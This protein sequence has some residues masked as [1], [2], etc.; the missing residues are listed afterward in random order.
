[1]NETKIIDAETKNIIGVA[2]I[3][4]VTELDKVLIRLEKIEKQLNSI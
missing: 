1:M 2:N 3:D 4:V